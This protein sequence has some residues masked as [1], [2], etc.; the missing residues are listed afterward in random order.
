MYELDPD[1]SMTLPADLIHWSWLKVDAD[2]VGFL[3]PLWI[4]FV[5]FA[6]PTASLWWIDRRRIPPGHCQRCGYNL[7]GNV[8]GL[9]PECGTPIPAGNAPEGWSDN[10]FRV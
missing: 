5:I 9:C 3:L 8:S 6:I 10:G 7:T 1:G 4:P 2:G